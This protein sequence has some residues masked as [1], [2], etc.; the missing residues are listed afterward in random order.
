MHNPRRVNANS[1]DLMAIRVGKQETVYNAQKKELAEKSETLKQTLTKL[2]TLQ[3]VKH[4]GLQEMSKQLIAVEEENKRLKE[5]LHEH[6]L[7][8]A[9]KPIQLNK[10]PM[11]ELDLEL[12][13]RKIE[14]LNTIA[15]RD[16]K[17]FIY[18]NGAYQLAVWN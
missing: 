10:E 15:K 18:R 1:L 4:N 12:V 6:G 13:A 8:W 5:F 17:P 9:G 14:E 3:E 16:A 2:K 7:R 11:K